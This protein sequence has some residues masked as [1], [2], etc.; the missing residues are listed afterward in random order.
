MFLGAV[1]ITIYHPIHVCCYMLG[2][3]HINKFQLPNQ[4]SHLLMSYSSTNS[5]HL[6]HLAL[7]WSIATLHVH[8][9][10]APMQFFFLFKYCIWFLLFL[11]WF[12][13]FHSCIITLYTYQSKL[14]SFSSSPHLITIQ[15][16]NSYTTA[17][18]FT[19]H[20]LLKINSSFNYFHASIICWLHMN[21]HSFLACL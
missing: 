19:L 3:H 16:F 10:F 21:L 14:V 8:Y 5:L 12:V 7:L 6:K 13:L 11:V 9:T 1:N 15:Y 17:L 20:L 18:H 4:P 2:S